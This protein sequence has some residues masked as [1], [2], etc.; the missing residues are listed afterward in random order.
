MT[1][2]ISRAEAKQAGLKRYFTGTRCLYGHVAERM[3]RNAD[4]VECRKELKRRKTPRLHLITCVVCGRD[5]QTTN[6]T[7]RT[8][9]LACGERRMREHSKRYYQ[10]HRERIIAQAKA[11]HANHFISKLRLCVCCG[12]TITTR[13]TK[14]CSHNCA[15]ALTRPVY[16]RDCGA[17]GRSFTARHKRKLTCSDECAAQYNTIAILMHRKTPAGRAQRRETQRRER[18][19]IAAAVAIA[20]E[21]KIPLPDLYELGVR[22]RRTRDK[23]KRA[24]WRAFREVG[25]L[26]KQR[27]MQA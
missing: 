12:S 6:P 20:R 26:P 17:C 22:E 18:A 3:V 4:C 16:T 10:E 7:Y 24:V 11:W 1:V 25:L 5:A 14:Y 8:C 19:R 23:A 21:M 27:R 13:R 2:V 9:S 15:K